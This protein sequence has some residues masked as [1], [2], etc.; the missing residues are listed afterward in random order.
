MAQPK[1]NNTEK[2]L[3]GCLLQDKKLIPAIQA[4]GG[5]KL[6]YFDRHINIFNAIVDQAEKG[7]VDIISVAARLDGLNSYL[8]E[9]AQQAPTPLLAP[10]YTETLKE[11][12]IKREIIT[13]CHNT[14]YHI[15]NPDILNQVDAG[16]H[17]IG[18]RVAK[19]K[20]TD[21]KNLAADLWEHY[22]TY[23]GTEPDYMRTG[24]VDLD[25][26]IDGIELTEHVIIAARPGQG[27][28][29]LAADIVR[30]ICK[31][32]KK[33]L[34]FTMEMSEQAMTRRIICAEAGINL[35]AYRN[36]KLSD[37]DKQKAIRAL[38][39][40]KDWQL[41]IIEGRVMVSDIKSLVLQQEPDLIVVDYLQ[42][43][44]I[45]RRGSMTTNDLVGDNVTGLQGIAKSGP[46]V[47]TLSQL[48]RASEKEKRR[49][50][51]SDLYES[52]KIEATG[53]KI[54]MPYRE[55]KEAEEAE[56]LVVKQKDGPVGKVEVLFDRV[57]VSFK[58]RAREHETPQVMAGGKQWGN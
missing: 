49:P 52:G 8:V 31:Q 30:N 57:S 20:H 54:L 38:S 45:D 55:D 2:A 23:E 32:G 24:L 34:F 13:L 17:E 40:V 27:K 22:I 3:L 50:G 53:D 47:I 10:T 37:I 16:V 35:K 4:A 26:V 42:L 11:L 48:S 18:K 21:I 51:L 28:T 44:P 14:I 12:Y 33:V 9:C 46:A 56:I 39:R 19:V 7:E 1:D 43:M 41:N 58:S 15:D 25:R 5:S 36:R 29:A 6:F